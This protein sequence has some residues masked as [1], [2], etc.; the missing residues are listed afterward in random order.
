MKITRISKI[1][2]SEF[3]TV[4]NRLKPETYSIQREP[5]DKREGC[6]NKGSGSGSGIDILC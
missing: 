4:K 3:L 2:R 6:E 5:N 1:D